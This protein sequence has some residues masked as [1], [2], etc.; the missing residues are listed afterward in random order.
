MIEKISLKTIRRQEFVDLTPKIQ[1]VIH[2]TSFKTGIIHVYVPH[3]TAAVTI[4]EN[5]DPSVV[6]DIL[7]TLEKLI[8]ERGR[9]SHLEGNAHAHIKASIIGSSRFIPIEDGRLQLG[10]WQGVFFCEFDG[11]RSREVWISF[12]PASAN[13]PGN[14]KKLIRSQ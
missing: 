11:P 12:L 6:Q 7:N 2:R 14:P 4:N 13:T 8:P 1:E 9:Y 3:T 5:Y 10:T